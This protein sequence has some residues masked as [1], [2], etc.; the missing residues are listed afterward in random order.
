MRVSGR[1]FVSAF[2]QQRSDADDSDMMYLYIYIYTYTYFHF[3]V[4]IYLFLFVNT[5]M[6]F[7]NSL[8]LEL[9]FVI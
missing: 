2:E 8:S 9:F 7:W 1:F 4:C 6:L 5:R 3:Y